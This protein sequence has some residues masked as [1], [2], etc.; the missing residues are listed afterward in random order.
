MGV[1]NVMSIY[2]GVHETTAD[3]AISK[4]EQTTIWDCGFYEFEYY[5][6]CSTNSWCCIK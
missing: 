3:R 4:Y 1:V 5:G 2:N 6:K